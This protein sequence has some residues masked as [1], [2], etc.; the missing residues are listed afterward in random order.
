[1]T[2]PILSVQGAVE[3]AAFDESMSQWYARRIIQRVAES[4][5]FTLGEM[6]AR[7][8]SPAVVWARW[9]AVA[10]VAT[11]FPLATL[12]ELGRWFNRNHSTILHALRCLGIEHQ[13]HKLL[14]VGRGYNL[15][16]PHRSQKE[17]VLSRSDLVAS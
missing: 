7:G 9:A 1:M 2:S 8:R 10:D 3:P 6:L 12:T 14:A 11:F 4:Y 17:R 13:G 16:Q 5:G 15:A